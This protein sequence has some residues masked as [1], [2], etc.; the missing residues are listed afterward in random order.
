MPLT[1]LYSEFNPSVTNKNFPV[2]ASDANLIT[3][4]G[5]TEWE[6]E[7]LTIYTLK[8][9]MLQVSERSVIVCLRICL[10]N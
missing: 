4:E 9:E 1:A 5:Y 3:P 10:V 2:L 7:R 6:D 8:A